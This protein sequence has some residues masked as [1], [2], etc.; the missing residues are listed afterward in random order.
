[1]LLLDDVLSELDTGRQRRLLAS[2]DG[3][4]TLVTGTG[5]DGFKEYGFKIDKTFHIASGDISGEF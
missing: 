2:I 5:M 3:I 1:M 4:Q